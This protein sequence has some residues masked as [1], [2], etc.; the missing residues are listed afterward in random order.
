MM[1]VDITCS[2]LNQFS[3]NFALKELLV[4]DL[5]IKDKES[6]LPSKQVFRLVRPLQLYDLF[7]WMI[8]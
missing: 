6:Y 4:N 8:L 5:H 2:V 3:S 1:W 7:D